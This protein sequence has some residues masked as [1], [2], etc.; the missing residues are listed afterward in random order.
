MKNSF[1]NQLT[2]HT[3]V[4]ENGALS[5]STTQN[6][7]V[8][9]F[10]KCATYRH[11]TLPQVYADVSKIWDTSPELT[12]QIVFYMRMITRK[13]KGFIASENV[14][15]GQGA[16][17]EFRKA[18][19]WL[20]LYQRETF[21]K[22]MWLIPVVGTWKD[23]WHEDVI[24]VLDTN[25]VYELVQKGI[26]DV[27][28]KDLIAKYL[29]RIRSKANVKNERHKKLN[30][31]AFDLCRHLG[32]TPK[33]YRLF[34]STGNA[35]DFQRKMSGGFWDELDFNKIPGKA[36]FQLVSTKGK[37]NLTT[38]E[39][40]GL[41]ERYVEWIKNKPTAKFTGYV[42]ELFNAVSKNTALSLAQKITYDKQFDGLI[43]L[44]KEDKGGLNGNV[45]C[46]LDISAS[47]TWETL[48]NKGTR[49]YDICLALGIY[50][51][52]LNEGAFHKSVVAFSDNSQDVQLKG[53]FTDMVNQIKMTNGWGSTNFQSVIDLMID[54]RKKYPSIPI[55]DYPKTLLVVSDMQFN[56]VG[57]NHKTNYEMM[58]SKLSR[59]FPK[60]FIENFRVIW[61]WVTGR[62]SDFPSTATDSGVTMMGGFDGSS[63]SL[64]LGG[65]PFTIDKET[66]KKRQ[67][68]PFEN[69]L[70][71]LNQEVLQQVKV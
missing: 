18:I 34:K 1:L 13:T 22:N 43:A 61:W 6:D 11:R 58:I 42:Y 3:T 26:D 33:E 30:A 71:V 31:W 12:L 28:N 51:S 66:G 56:P 55:E 5:L 59:H 68:N 53:S 46:A 4:T 57:G 2:K 21:S 45:W 62:A 67:L 64:I 17:D 38:L 24:D 23:L 15:K 44:A 47:M 54:I 52:T 36:L 40:H 35:H 65:E 20:S 27:Y 19:Y 70:K 8:D 7:L 49:P 29:P 10:S 14:Q 9:Y 39:R 32:W 60:E 41:E 50:F 37:D 48:D 25:A 63:V 16:R 69:M